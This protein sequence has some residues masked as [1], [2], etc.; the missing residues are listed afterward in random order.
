MWALL[1]CDEGLW[2]LILNL[3]VTMWVFVDFIGLIDEKT[4]R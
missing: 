4:L 1:F 2:D 3:R